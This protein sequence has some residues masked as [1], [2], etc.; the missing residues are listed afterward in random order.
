MNVND[1][2]EQVVNKFIKEITDQVFLYIERDD[3]LMR[4]HMSMVRNEG[5]KVDIAIG[6]KVKEI[7]NL[8]NIRDD[9]Q[10]KSRLI[11]TY[12]SHKS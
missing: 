1:Y 6:K 5:G 2:A 9:E 4:E 10:P 3:A 12:T 11:E 8:D 7:L